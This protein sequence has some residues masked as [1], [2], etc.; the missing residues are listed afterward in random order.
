MQSIVARRLITCLES[1]SW[2]AGVTRLTHSWPADDAFALHWLFA[3][4]VT[5]VV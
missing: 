5:P 4:R 2:V 3:S 1:L